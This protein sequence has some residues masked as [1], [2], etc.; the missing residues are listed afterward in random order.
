M[1]IN[2]IAGIIGGIGNMLQNTVETVN[3][4]SRKIMGRWFQVLY[5]V[6]RFFCIILPGLF[7]M[8]HLEQ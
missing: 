3:V 6:V 5:F 7:H 8:L 1:D 2:T 4:P